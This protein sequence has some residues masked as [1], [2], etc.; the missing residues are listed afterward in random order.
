MRKY[1]ASE[2]SFR[3]WL[4][5]AAELLRLH[6]EIGGKML[7]FLQHNCFPILSYT[8]HVQFTLAWEEEKVTHA[9]HRNA[10]ARPLQ[11]ARQRATF[12]APPTLP[13][14]LVLGTAILLHPKLQ[15]H[16]RQFLLL[17][18][19][20]WTA[21]L[22]QWHTV[23]TRLPHLLIG[24]RLRITCQRSCITCPWCITCP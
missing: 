21:F 17:A 5:C 12:P 22:R 11:C 4:L 15:R 18:G 10:K 14:V 24:Q 16:L 23:R 20:P 9:H 2:A 8:P 13:G 7:F 19:F 6:F 3:K 1:T